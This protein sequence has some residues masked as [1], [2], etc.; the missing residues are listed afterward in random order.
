MMLFAGVGASGQKEE[1]SISSSRDGVDSS[2]GD[3]QTP[4]ELSGDFQ[5]IPWWRD[6]G[7]CG[8]LALFVLM[9]LEGEHPTVDD[10]KR[11]TPVDL[12]RGCSL[13]DLRQTAETLGMPTDVRFVNPR[14]LRDVP[15]P[16]VLHGITSVVQ[17]LGHFFVV[18]DYD[19]KKKAY[20]LIDPVEERF[21]WNPE[22]SLLY[23]YTGYVLVPRYT[24]GQK[25][26]LLAAYYWIFAGGTVF[27]LWCYSV[28]RRRRRVARRP[29][30][31]A[32]D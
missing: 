12:K 17:D 25:W 16:F 29:R 21:S 7:D 23:G 1:R 22:A 31:N 3:S 11:L 15:R 2:F 28:F 24:A 18:V 4:E 10:V 14:D 32:E 27:C 13:E 8:P 5:W 20:A 30:R 19:P 6:R 9:K 26:D